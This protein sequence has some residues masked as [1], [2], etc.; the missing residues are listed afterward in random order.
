MVFAKLMESW[1]GKAQAKE[2]GRRWTGRL[3]SLLFPGGF[4]RSGK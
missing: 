2:R 3:I 4:A 1:P